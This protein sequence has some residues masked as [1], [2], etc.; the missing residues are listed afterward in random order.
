M[1][2]KAEK[3]SASKNKAF[4]EK[5]SLLDKELTELDIILK[6]QEKGM[7][8]HD[9]A[10]DKY[11]KEC[12]EKIQINEKKRIELKEI[13]NNAERLDN[14]TEVLDFS[15]K[16]PS[17]LAD[18]DQSVF[19]PA[20]LGPEESLQKEN[21][22]PEEF[23]VH[24]IGDEDEMP[25]GEDL[26]E[27]SF[28]NEE[29]K[30]IEFDDIQ[31]IFH[32]TKENQDELGAP[33]VFTE[34]V[35]QNVLEKFNKTKKIPEINGFLKKKSGKVKI[36]QKRYFTC[37]GNELF[38]L[39]SPKD[40]ILR[41]CINF[42]VCD[43][44]LVEKKN[45]K[46]FGIKMKGLKREIQLK[47]ETE[48]QASSWK[49]IIQ[50]QIDQSDGKKFSKGIQVKKWWKMQ[51]CDFNIFLSTAS[52]GDLL[53]YYMRDE[54]VQ[55]DDHQDDLY[56]YALIVKSVQSQFQFNV[57]FYDCVL[58]DYKL[59]S[60]EEFYQEICD[61][62]FDDLMYRKVTACR[63]DEYYDRQKESNLTLPRKNLPNSSKEC[64]CMLTWKE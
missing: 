41:G 60:F 31:D 42:D 3:S 57:F 50:Q 20:H 46:I 25:L 26:G 30:E 1:W 13:S 4:Q 55:P 47:A 53:I 62:G 51:E 23:I 34:T 22:E 40:S 45:K 44:T 5:I 17:Q 49:A 58:C 61:K 8:K 36:W 29:H 15:F 24:E 9:E 43:V 14:E 2:N 10:C 7:K 21:D 28:Y 32:K 48:V 64:K 11:K 52:S 37:R 33:D 16:D 63:D 59:C 56:H 12:M 6:S 54:M 19:F 18:F 27:D 39:K 38:Y 35:V